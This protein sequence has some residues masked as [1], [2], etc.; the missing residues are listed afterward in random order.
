MYVSDLR[1]R[2]GRHMEQMIAQSER[3]MQYWIKVPVNQLGNKYLE[4]SKELVVALTQGEG[5]IKQITRELSFLCFL[6][7]EHGPE[8]KEVTSRSKGAPIT[9]VRVDPD[10]EKE[11]E[12]RAAWEKKNKKT[13][14]VKKEDWRG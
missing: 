12:E 4:K 10:V 6:I 14:A 5:D 8:I 2:L 3:A 11:K 7:G 1:E 13:K 9:E